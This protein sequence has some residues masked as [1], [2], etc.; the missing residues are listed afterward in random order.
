[1]GSRIVRLSASNVKR[2]TAVDIAPGPESSVV[3][4]G[5]K[6]AQ[7]KSSVLDAISFALGGKDAIPSQPVR[8]GAK[9]ATIDLDLGDLKVTRQISP[10]G[11]GSLVVTDAEGAK[12]SSPQ[13]LLDKLYAH[14]AFDPLEYMREKPDRQGAVLRELVGL[15][16]SAID[17]EVARLRA[18]RTEVG[19]SWKRSEARLAGIQKPAD[20]CPAGEVSVA[21][22]A[23]A[24]QAAVSRQR[25]VERERERLRLAAERATETVEGHQYDVA[26]LKARIEDLERHLTS[27]RAALAESERRVEESLAAQQSARLALCGA[28]EV[29]AVDAEKAALD[30]AEEHNRKARARA[31][32]EAARQELKA[33][34]DQYREFTRRIERCD[35]Q[36][37]EKLAA[38]AMPVP[39]LSFSSDGGVLYNGLPLD[40]ASQAE[41]IRVSVAIGLA[42]NPSLRV[43]LVRDGSLLDDD[44]LRMLAELAAANDAQVW[45]ERVGDGEECSV[46]IED[47]HV[48]GAGEQ[49]A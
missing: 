20:D 37:A 5:G 9:R 2:L 12:K 7:G 17:A 16:T 38:V 14:H 29:P 40:Q 3:V 30:G 19:K 22:L 34:T 15:D 33:A 44:G 10:D 27:E 8:R 36:K 46:V 28:P 26:S 41:Q 6:N 23:N 49:A 24:Y 21:E 31:A 35:E 48:R 45:I 1:M 39:G 47:G 11:G 42:Q 43:L 32:Y 25:E 18:E 4:I 13:T